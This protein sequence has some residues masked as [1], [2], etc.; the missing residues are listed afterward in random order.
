[1]AVV[2]V[3]LAGCGS[4]S[5]RYQPRQPPAA[6][7]P[8]R[9][10]EL[11]RPVAPN[12]KPPAIRLAQLLPGPTWPLTEAPSLEPHYRVASPWFAACD[13]RGHLPD[14]ALAYV[15]AWC[16]Y[17]RDSSFDVV[18]ALLPQRS[19]NV[20]GLGD[21]IRHDVANLVADRRSG[22]GAVSWLAEDASHEDAL[23]E[24]LIAVYTDLGRIDDAAI[25]AKEY[26]ERR[27]PRCSRELVDAKFALV[28]YGDRWSALFVRARS[29]GL[30]T[31]CGAELQRI[32]CMFWEGARQT[33]TKVSQLQPRKDCDGLAARDLA[34]SRVIAATRTWAAPSDYVALIEAATLAITALDVPEAEDLAL[35]ALEAS[36][37]ASPASCGMTDRVVD[38]AAVIDASP[39]AEPRFA[40]R[41]AALRAMT[42]AACE[43]RR[44]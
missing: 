13:R 26:V 31:S 21:A 5:P 17:R 36:L 30:G 41:R 32:G 20:L 40:G 28:S 39:H 43:A 2:A 38:L 34:A 7:R 4:P 8:G 16:R 44:N 23:Y 25:V 10:D 9:P 12:P 22:Q 14:D 6:V 24:L 33:F 19:S 37:E 29:Y 1:M 3:A 42:P 27:S 11:P 18:A 35:T 15:E